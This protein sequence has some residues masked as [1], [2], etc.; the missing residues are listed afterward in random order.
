MYISAEVPAEDVAAEI[1]QDGELGMD[2]LA[3]LAEKPERAIK[4]LSRGDTGSIVHQS[5][6]AFLRR[7]ADALEDTH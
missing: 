3:F 4:E 1:L 7:L 6:P 2:I 5:V